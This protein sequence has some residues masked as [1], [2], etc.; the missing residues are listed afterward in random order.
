MLFLRVKG[1]PPPPHPSGRFSMQ[2]LFVRAPLLF[3]EFLFAKNLKMLRTRVE[4]VV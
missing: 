2:V 3:L 4:N 1:N